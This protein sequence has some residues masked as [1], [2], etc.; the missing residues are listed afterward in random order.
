NAVDYAGGRASCAKCHSHEGL[1]QFAELGTVAGDI[2]NP[3]AW[4]GKT[5][6]NIHETFEPSD[7]ALRLDQP[8]QAMYNPVAS[9]YLI[10]NN[11]LCANCHQSRAAEPAL[12]NPDAETFRITTTH[13]GPHYSTQANIVAGMGMAEIA[14]SVDYPTSNYHLNDQ[15][16]CN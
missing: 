7:Y 1:V 10:G 2:T 8:V 11:N 6:H 4:Q 9:F 5:C 14:G 15:A 13:Y 16:S 3:T 12:A